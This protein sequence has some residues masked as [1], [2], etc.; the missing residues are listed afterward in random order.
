MWVIDLV[1]GFIGYS[2]VIT[3]RTIN[4]TTLKIT[5]TI[6]YK[7]KSSASVCF[8]VAWSLEFSSHL[9]ISTTHCSVSQSQSH[10]ATDG[11][12]VSKS[13]CRAPTGDHDHIFITI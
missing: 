3:T 6:T 5:A 12:S 7:V 11:Q 1:I 10:I 2:Q 4:Y 9:L 13:W 8:V